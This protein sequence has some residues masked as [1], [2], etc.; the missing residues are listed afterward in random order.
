MAPSEA[1][2]FLPPYRNILNGRA[3]WEPVNVDGFSLLAQF[4]EGSQA[5][6]NYIDFTRVGREI[7]SIIDKPDYEKNIRAVGALLRQQ[8]VRQVDFIK[9]NSVSEL[10]WKL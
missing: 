9:E 4:E 8:G 7:G 10:L 6:W 1:R 2:Q 3:F 5:G